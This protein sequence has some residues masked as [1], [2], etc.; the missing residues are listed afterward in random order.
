MI[1]GMAAGTMTLIVVCHFV[2]PRARL[3]SRRERETLR[4]ASSEV[5]M[6]V[7]SSMIVMVSVP[8]IRPIPILRI[9]TKT[10]KPKSPKMIEGIPARVSVPK[11]RILTSIPCRVYSVR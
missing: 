9:V 3:P 7:G 11:R 2:A 4:I 10:M 5:R 6:I 8:E 1:P